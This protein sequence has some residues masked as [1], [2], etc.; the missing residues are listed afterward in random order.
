MDL[1]HECN[2]DGNLQDFAAAI[3]ILVS[4]PNA[5][6]KRLV[7]AEI[8]NVA[9]FT[10]NKF[11]S[12][13]NSFTTKEFVNSVL[14]EHRKNLVKVKND[15][16]LEQLS[17]QILLPQLEVGSNC[18]ITRKCVTR[19]RSRNLVQPNEKVI[20]NTDIKRDDVLWIYAYPNNLQEMQSAFFVPHS[21]NDPCYA[22]VYTSEIE[23]GSANESIVNNPNSVH[24]IEIWLENIHTLPKSHSKWI[25][26]LKQKC[27]KSVEKWCNA[28]IGG[29]T[30]CSKCKPESTIQPPPSL[31]LVSLEEYDTLY[32]QIKAKYVKPLLESNAW[33]TESTDPDKF[34][35]EDVGI[36]V[37]LMLLWKHSSKKPI[38]AKTLSITEV[39][40]LRRV[41]L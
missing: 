4:K 19:K 3:H 35:H 28:K 18:L 14:V 22:I 24:K 12:S 17:P 6:N 38:I 15:T 37:Y 31:R 40:L 5:V 16:Y 36:A 21:P 33:A 23:T 9:S 25:R 30:T 1:L 32:T 8:Q 41:K 34:I 10:S 13:Y 26:W 11:A 27:F 2:I 29:E 7:G 39:Q 20:E